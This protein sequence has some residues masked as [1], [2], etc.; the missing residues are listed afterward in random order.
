MTLDQTASTLLAPVGWSDGSAS[1]RATDVVLGTLLALAAVPVIL[2]LAVAVA[3]TLRTNPFFVQQRVGLGGRPIPLVK[4]RTLPR[5]A[6]RYAAKHELGQ[7]VIPAFTAWLRRAH[8]DELPQLFLVPLGYLSLVGPRPEMPALH[9]AADPDF[10]AR[11]V[12]VRP[13]CTGLWQISE[14]T[15]GLIWHNPHY[16]LLYLRNRSAALDVWIL[17]RTALVLTG[18]GRPLRL[19]VLQPVAVP[20]A[21]GR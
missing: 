5:S 6:P 10:A 21:S 2:A 15:T 12:Q 13:G 19:S 20:V 16:D 18:H 14:A 9:R 7:V 4:L 1:K 3:L 17:W 11:R 8:L